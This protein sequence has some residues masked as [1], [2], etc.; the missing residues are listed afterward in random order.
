MYQWGIILQL[1]TKHVLRRF[2]ILLTF[3]V[4]F[5]L[6]VAGEVGV[7]FSHCTILKLFVPEKLCF[8][9]Q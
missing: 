5:F 1:Q 9:N 4:M 6:M 3:M 8:Y 7:Q 2:T